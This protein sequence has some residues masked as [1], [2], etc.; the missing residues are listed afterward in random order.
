MIWGPEKARIV[1]K[2]GENMLSRRGSKPIHLHHK[3]TKS[4]QDKFRQHVVSLVSMM[5]ELE[6]PFLENDEALVCLHTRDI[7]ENIVCDTINKIESVEIEK[8]QEFFAEK[9]V[10]KTKSIDDTLHKNK[11]SLFS[12]KPPL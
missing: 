4:F 1:N 2:F 6:N 9:L 7:V 11:L 12:Y 5:E 8:S 3:Q 10:K